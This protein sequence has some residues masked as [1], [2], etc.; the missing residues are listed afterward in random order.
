M[1][2]L[3]LKKLDNYSPSQ[4]HNLLKKLMKKDFSTLDPGVFISFILTKLNEEINY[5][6]KVIKN[7][8]NI[9]L[10]HKEEVEKFFKEYKENNTTQISNDFYIVT[11]T[12]KKCQRFKEEGGIE[13]NHYYFDYEP[14]INL[15]IKKKIMLKVLV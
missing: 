9:N 5:N 15:Y 4:I 13:I 2:N 12:T 3:W 1:N 14:I 8:N 6:K 10:T 11:Q 7:K